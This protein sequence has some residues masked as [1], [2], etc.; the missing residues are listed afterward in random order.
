MWQ[1]RFRLSE[2]LLLE[3]ISVPIANWKRRKGSAPACPE[4]LGDTQVNLMATVMSKWLQA[5]QQAAM[6]LALRKAW[7]PVLT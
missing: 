3:P 5:S 7:F 6:K 4:E 2:L 1:T